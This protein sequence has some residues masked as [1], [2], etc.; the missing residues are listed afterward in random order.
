[1]EFEDLGS[2]PIKVE[3][4]PKRLIVDDEEEKEWVNIQPGK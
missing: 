3:E 1:M 2:S 4:Q